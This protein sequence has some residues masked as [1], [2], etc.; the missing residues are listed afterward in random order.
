MNGVSGFA[1]HPSSFIVHTASIPSMDPIQALGSKEVIIRLLTAM[2]IGGVIGF[3]RRIN[4]KPAGLR[5]HALV[6]MGAAVITISSLHFTDDGHVTNPD[7]LSRVI[8][9]IITGIGFLG[10]GVIIR[11][12]TG[13]QV[14][15]LTTAA[16]IWGAAS[17][18][19]ACGLGYWRFVLMAAS[20]MLV[21]LI[22][23]GPFE[24]F[25][26]HFW[27]KWIRREK[28]LP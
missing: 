17:L 24:R 7:A 14:Y 21:V 27:R 19:I 18:G 4:N 16:T 25:I 1:F 10:A 20:L 13:I 28:E 11:D 12:A 2:S 26:E 15:G 3:N 23:G 8:Q 22:A 5:T 9:G 6:T